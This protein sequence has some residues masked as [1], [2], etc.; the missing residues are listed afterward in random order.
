M[1]I[2]DARFHGNDNMEILNSR[3]F[4]FREDENEKIEVF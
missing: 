4:H 1:E 3:S 2:Q